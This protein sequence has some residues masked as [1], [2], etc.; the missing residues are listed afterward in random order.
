MALEPK[1]QKGQDVI[2]LS[3]DDMMAALDLPTT[4]ESGYICCWLTSS[5]QARRW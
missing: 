5:V 3:Y 4:F 2:V 1:S